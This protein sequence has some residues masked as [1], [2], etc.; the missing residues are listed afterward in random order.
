MPTRTREE[1]VEYA[2]K[3]IER[4]VDESLE[5]DPVSYWHRT[6]TAEVNMWTGIVLAMKE[7]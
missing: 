4:I 2:R 5:N 7:D 3:Q 1:V 6:G